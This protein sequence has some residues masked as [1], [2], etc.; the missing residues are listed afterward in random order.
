MAGDAVTGA[1]LLAVVT[2][3]RPGT[4]GFEFSRLCREIAEGL[5]LDQVVLE[6]AAAFVGPGTG[7]IEPAAVRTEYRW[8][9]PGS[10]GR[11][12]RLAVRRFPVL[13]AGEQVGL[14]KLNAGAVRRLGPARSRILAD[15]VD[16]LGPVLYLARLEQDR[17]LA[18][19]QARDQAER[20]AVVRRQSFAQRDQERRDLERDLHDGAQHHLVAL[21]MAVGLLEVRSATGDP[22]AAR[23]V[24]AGL[25]S[26]IAQAGQILLS[27]AAGSC[28]PVLVESGLG[29][30]LTAEIVDRR[31]Q[32]QLR[33]AVEPGR[34]FPLAIETAVFF[35]CLE[36]VHNARKHAPGAQVSVKLWEQPGELGFSVADNGPGLDDPDPAGSF[37]LD[38]MRSRI[39]A[40]GGSL[41]LWTL[42]GSGT[43]IEGLVPL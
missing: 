41:K 19:D 17:A 23:V 22:V 21:R 12:S 9:V 40:V 8:A 26:K 16:A 13:L 24:V 37:G 25:R 4:N 42:P 3:M 18:L 35:T 39:H 38:N 31:D 1:D 11:I 10:A 30:A 2:R 43:T 29:P 6:L 27:T 32:V 36:A 5:G 20:I 7:P 28:P 14:L 34:R 33:S 15:V